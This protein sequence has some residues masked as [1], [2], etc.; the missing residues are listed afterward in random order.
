MSRPIPGIFL[1]LLLSLSLSAQRIDQTASFRNVVGNNY[2]RFHYDNDFVGKTDYYYTQGYS[3]EIVAPALRKNPVNKLLVKLNNSYSKYGLTFEHYGFTPTSIKS[4]VIL[5]NDRP[6][7]GCIMLKSFRISVDTVQKARLTS[8]ISTGMIG[9]AAFAS[10]MQSTI[11][12]WTGDQDPKGWQYQIR[13]DLILNY[14]LNYEKLI[15]KYANL[16]ELNTNT[17]LRLGTLS[18]KL[19]AGLT[20]K[21]GNI[22]SI[23]SRSEKPFSRNF[24]IYIYN[25]P[26]V[27]LVGYDAALSGGLFSRNSPYTLS[28]S[29]INRVTFQDNFGLV[30]HCWRLY[31]EYYQSFLTKEFKTGWDH[32]WGG[33][34]IGF[35]I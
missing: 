34:K 32:R 21:L 35:A 23:F 13:N 14:E 19:Q 7:A 11:H 12:K 22:N 1:F 26:L 9:P 2:I 30:V 3:F 10:R 4:N 28:S 29:Q 27:S 8:V 31:I 18:D 6:F 5:Y 33:V 15:Y 17:Q 24:Q 20:L 16:F 25:Q